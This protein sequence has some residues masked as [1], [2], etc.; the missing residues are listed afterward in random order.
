MTNCMSVGNAYTLIKKKI[1]DIYNIEHITVH[2]DNNHR[3]C[4]ICDLTNTK[5][6]VIYTGVKSIS[7]FP[8]VIF[9]LRGK[10]VKPFM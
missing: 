1:L 7:L 2:G 5:T 9:Y 4:C 3:C 8:E 6:L 10:L